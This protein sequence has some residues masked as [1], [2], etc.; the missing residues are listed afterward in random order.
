MIVHSH[1]HTH[2]QSDIGK[3]YKTEDKHTHIQCKLQNSHILYKDKADIHTYIDS[4]KRTHTQ[5]FTF[6]S[7]NHHHLLLLLLLLLCL[8][9]LDLLALGKTGGKRHPSVQSRRGPYSL[10]PRGPVTSHT[11]PSNKSGGAIEWIGRVR[12]YL[13]YCTVFYVVVLVIQYSARTINNFFFLTTEFLQL[14]GIGEV[15]DNLHPITNMK[16][17]GIGKVKRLGMFS[18]LTAILRIRGLKRLGMLFK[19][20]VCD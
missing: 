17:Y 10:V 11:R 13:S 6:S 3:T 12:G 1:T 14:C 19:Y 9:W 15:R 4:H 5:N 7:L 20:L 18:H 8:L 2:T 16:V